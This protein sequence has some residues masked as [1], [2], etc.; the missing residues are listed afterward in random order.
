MFMPV[1]SLFPLSNALARST[2][3]VGPAVWAVMACQF[4]CN[5]M[6]EVSFGCVFIY[7]TTA[8]PSP[9]LLGATN[10][11][12]QTTVSISRAAARIT[13]AGLFAFSAEHNLLGGYA[14]YVVLIV[15]TSLC[16]L[17]AAPLPENGWDEGGDK[18]NGT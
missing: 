6:M 17:V 13:A 12:S 4:V 3:G 14:V 1:Y 7:I 5:L 11:L 8:A 15:L 9:R 18:L 16:L 2:G 10:G